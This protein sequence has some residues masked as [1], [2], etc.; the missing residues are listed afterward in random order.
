MIAFDLQ[1]GCGYCFEGWFESREDF[2][3]QQA[4]GLINCPSC[5]G[6][7]VRKILSP[8]AIGRPK[9]NQ[10]VENDRA[11]NF[12]Q[13][14]VDFFKNVQT[15][16]EKNFDDVGSRFAE[17][18]LKMHY[19]VSEPRNIRGVTT[20]DEEKMLESEGVDT[21]KVPIV[22]EKPDPDYH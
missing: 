10:T 11:A 20:E 12:D 22:K 9:H 15:F 5:E 6:L 14:L 19:G 1:C 3:R 16:V 18:S 8:V 2:D 4:K 17:E 13:H 21:L 7:E